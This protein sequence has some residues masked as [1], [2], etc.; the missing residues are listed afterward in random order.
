MLGLIHLHFLFVSSS[1]NDGRKQARNGKRTDVSQ[2]DTKEKRRR[3]NVEVSPVF[4]LVSSAFIYPK[5]V[6]LGKEP[7]TRVRAIGIVSS[8]SSLIPFLKLRT[9]NTLTSLLDLNPVC[10]QVHTSLIYR[11]FPSY[12]IFGGLFGTNLKRQYDVRKFH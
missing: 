3:A 10:V 11:A 4:F 2:E 6:S 7:E 5:S 12:R 8:Q 9:V 1:T